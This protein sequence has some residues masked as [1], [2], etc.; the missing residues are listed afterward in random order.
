MPETLKCFVTSE[1]KTTLTCPKCQKT[2]RVDVS[3]FMLLETEAK[4]K[5][6]CNC[7]NHFKVILE[8]RRSIR[9]NIS[10][11]GWI[12]Y[13]ANKHK[14]KV[15]EISKHG[16][17]I[18]LAKELPIET[19]V[20]INLEFTIDDQMNSLIT[21]QVEV[22]KKFSSTRLGCEFLNFEHSGNLGKY[23]LFYF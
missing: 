20:K 14:I 5:C 23:F 21:R 3:K 12:E 10:F 16:L 13:K 22:K 6:K 19:G 18:H 4:L 8:R 2:K 11:P 7:G 15:I 9:K 17:Q 1:L